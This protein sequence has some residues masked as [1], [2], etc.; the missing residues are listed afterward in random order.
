VKQGKFSLC[1]YLIFVLIAFSAVFGALL[2]LLEP[3]IVVVEGIN[4]SVKHYVASVKHSQ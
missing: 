2:I 1:F 3:L 4:S